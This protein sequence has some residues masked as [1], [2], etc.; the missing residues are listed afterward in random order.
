METGYDWSKTTTSETSEETTT[1]VE[2]AIPGGT[3]AYI[4]QAVGRC[5]YSTVKTRMFKVEEERMN[6]SGRSVGG[7]KTSYVLELL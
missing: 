7:S 1:T 2:V 6:P 3:R 4:S 5:G